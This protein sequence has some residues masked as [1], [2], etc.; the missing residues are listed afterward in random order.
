MV[1]LAQQET[2]ALAQLL[3]SQKQV[4]NTEIQELTDKA[5]KELQDAQKKFEEVK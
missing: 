5:K 1:S 3:K 2:V 4:H